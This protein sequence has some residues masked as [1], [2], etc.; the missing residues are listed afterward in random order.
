MLLRV[1]IDKLDFRLNLIEFAL[2]DGLTEDDA[3][4]SLHILH[5]HS[6]DFEFADV[7]DSLF[8]DVTSSG[9]DWNIIIV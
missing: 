3:I 4:A 5:D 2:V 8:S 7:H 1:S 9:H 6:L